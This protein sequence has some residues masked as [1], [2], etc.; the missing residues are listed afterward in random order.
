MKKEAKEKAEEEARQIAMENY[1]K[2]VEAQ[3][4]VKLNT[5]TV[6]AEGCDG[7]VYYENGTFYKPSSSLVPKNG[8]AKTK[9][10]ATAGYNKYFYEYLNSFVE[11]AKKEGHTI[12]PSPNEGDGAWRSFERQQYWWEYYHHDN[13]KAAFP[14]TSNHGWAIASDLRF[15]NMESDLY[16][17][18]DH[19]N[20]YNLRFPLCQNVRTGPCGE[21][22]HIEPLSISVNDEKAKRCL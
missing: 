11:A 13:S 21:N 18:H 3:N 1:K 14:G 8:I 5:I 20:E 9:G 19:A 12:I 2:R 16:W 15:G 17:A 10:S 4:Q 6:K 7:V 22:W